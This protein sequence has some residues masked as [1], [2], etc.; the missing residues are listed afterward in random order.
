ML[1]MA[2]REETYRN[3]ILCE[4]SHL[5]R[6]ALIFRRDGVVQ[7]H[8]D[9]EAKLRERL[10][11][12]KKI[13]DDFVAHSQPEDLVMLEAP[14]EYTFER[15]RNNYKA[16]EF[17]KFRRDWERVL[18]R[19]FNLYHELA[20]YAMSKGRVVA[21]LEPKATRSAGGISK[22]LARIDELS[23]E[24]VTRLEYFMRIRRN[25]LIVRTV[26]LEKP[27]L[28]IAATGHVLDLEKMGPRKVIWHR[29]ISDAQRHQIR[30]SLVALKQQYEQV[31]KERK[32]RPKRK[33]K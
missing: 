14:E 12:G 21:S 20:E 27:K 24:R 10:E 26:Q 3:F 23:K 18:K 13:I 31:K 9:A 25:E 28:V 15:F 17:E 5:T 16:T 29:R 33:L 4:V 22:D 32:A 19:H 30:L 7:I 1:K 2:N 8:P 6:S 11:F